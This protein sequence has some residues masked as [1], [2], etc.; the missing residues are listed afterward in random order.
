[1]RV[2]IKKKPL[3]RIFV[4]P[5]LFPANLVLTLAAANSASLTVGEILLA[6]AGLSALAGLVFGAMILLLKMDGA[7][8]AFLI[9]VGTLWVGNFGVLVNLLQ[10]RLALPMNG[11][12]KLLVFLIWSCFFGLLGSKALWRLVRSPETI[13]S[14]LNILSIML[15]IISGMRIWNFWGGQINRATYADSF[16]PLRNCRDNG[17]KPDIYYIIMDGYGRKDSLMEYYGFDNS[18]FIQFLERQGFYVAGESN[19]NYAQTGLSIS[20][21][22]NF[23]YLPAFQVTSRDG[24]PLIWLIQQSRLRKT[25]EGMGYSSYAFQ[26]PYDAA[27]IT[28]SDYFLAGAKMAR[29]QALN[30]LLLMNSVGSIGVDFGLLRPPISSYGEQHD[31]ILNNLHLLKQ[32][33]S[34][35]G[36]KF[37]FMHLI[38]PHPPFIFNERG[39]IQRNAVYILTDGQ[40]FSGS[41]IQYRQGYSSQLSYLNMMIKDVIT[42]ILRSSRTPPVIILQGDHGPGA[43]F[44]ENLSETCLKERFPILNAYLLP[45]IV[46]GELYPFISPVNTFRLVLDHYFEAGLGQLENRQ[47]FSN[48]ARPYQ[49]ID[50]TGQI[51]RDCRIP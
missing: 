3:A 32:I 19:A 49:W 16:P 43:Y 20:S 39:P 10:D 9:F 50:V 47:Y 30:G 29:I 45:G 28:Q 6:T 13:T 48:F 41:S 27:N 17:Q 14:Y 2:E 40:W 34:R 18:D 36:S 7:R 11:S 35:T 21:S 1:M 23:D 15:V 38:L 8:T 24:R 37:I 46:P 44:T 5:I 26:T 33:S 42:T 12:S 51:E 25:L 31:M 4:Y 22:L